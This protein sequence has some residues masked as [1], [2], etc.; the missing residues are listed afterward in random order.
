MDEADFFENFAPNGAISNKLTG[1]NP[2]GI[3]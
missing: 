3:A 1:D 2:D